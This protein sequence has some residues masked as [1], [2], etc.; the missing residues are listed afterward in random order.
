MDLFFLILDSSKDT[1]LGG[2]GGLIGGFY[3]F[4]LKRQKNADE[5]M[6]FT[7]LWIHCISGVFMAYCCSPYIPPDAEYRRLLIGNLGL[8]G[9]PLIGLIQSK[10]V[11]KVVSIFK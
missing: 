1:L 9:L 5:R 2:V 3:H 7:E 10:G 11:A 4:Y 6:D 8:S